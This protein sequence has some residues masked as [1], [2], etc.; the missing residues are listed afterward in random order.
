MILIS[1]S[2]KITCSKESRDVPLSTNQRRPFRIEKVYVEWKNSAQVLTEF[3]AYF[4]DFFEI[5]GSVYVSVQTHVMDQ[6]I[7]C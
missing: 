2:V 7:T 6:N 4:L 1:C 5:F 3:L